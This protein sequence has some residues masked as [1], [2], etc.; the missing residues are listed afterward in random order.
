VI[1][2]NESHAEVMRWSFKEGWL[3]KWEGPGLNATTNE[4]AIESLEIVHEG[5]DFEFTG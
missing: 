2:R 3:T 4:A 5:L 1:L